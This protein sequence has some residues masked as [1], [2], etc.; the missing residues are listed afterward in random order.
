MT[1]RRAWGLLLQRGSEKARFAVPI[2]FRRAEK[3]P[4]GLPQA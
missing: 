4:P 2:V 1:S 3:L